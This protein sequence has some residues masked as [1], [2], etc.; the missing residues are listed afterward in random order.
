MKNYRIYFLDSLGKISGRP[1]ELQGTSDGEVIMRALLAERNVHGAEV[2]CGA[3]L[4]RRVDQHTRPE[5]LFVKPGEAGA[6]PEAR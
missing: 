3:T 1:A 5:A 2:W 6:Q 4:V